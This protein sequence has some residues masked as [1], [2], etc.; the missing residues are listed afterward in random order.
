MS[1]KVAVYANFG[2]KISHFRFESLA[3]LQLGGPGFLQI[4]EKKAY[5]SFLPQRTP[6]Q[7]LNIYVNL[8]CFNAHNTNLNPVGFCGPQGPLHW[9]SYLKRE[10]L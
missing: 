6:E 1:Q 8:I 10:I 4:L 5:F 7:K 3:P 2:V 9:I